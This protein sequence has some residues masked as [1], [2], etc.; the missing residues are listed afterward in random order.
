M[1]NVYEAMTSA[2]AMRCDETEGGEEGGDWRPR[3]SRVWRLKLFSSVPADLCLAV[4]C[5]TTG[6]NNRTTM[7]LQSNSDLPSTADAVTS[8]DLCCGS[9]SS[10]DCA[11]SGSRSGTAS[12]PGLDIVRHSRPR[13]RS[14]SVV[15]SL[16]NEKRY[17]LRLNYA[18]PTSPPFKNSPLFFK[19]SAKKQAKPT[20]IT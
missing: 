3:P 17:Q 4:D 7:L 14:S 13:F 1:D 12:S 11:G 9:G 8:V 5:C 18:V 15:L 20:D 6:T 10:S 16:C 19:V 2:T